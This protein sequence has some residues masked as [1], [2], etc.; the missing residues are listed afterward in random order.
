MKI[1]L[2]RAAALSNGQL[3]VLCV[4]WGPYAGWQMFISRQSFHLSEENNGLALCPALSRAN[5]ASYL[6]SNQAIIHFAQNTWDQAQVQCSICQELGKLLS[7][8]T[9]LLSKIVFNV[10]YS[11][12]HVLSCLFFLVAF[13]SGS[14]SVIKKQKS[15]FTAVFARFLPDLLGA[16]GCSMKPG[17]FYKF[18]Y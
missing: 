11:L 2:I 3:K 15:T 10:H 6:T 14:Y 13:V 7:W 17:L 18:S 8:R 16:D 4:C 5:K 12:V 9:V 1:F